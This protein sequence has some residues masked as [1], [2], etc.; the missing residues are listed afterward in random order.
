MELATDIMAILGW[1]LFGHL[2]P[3]F[4]II[5]KNGIDTFSGYEV[6]TERKEF[7]LVS[8]ISFALIAASLVLE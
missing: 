7:R 8:A 3:V 2:L 1:G 5:Y 4:V 6:G